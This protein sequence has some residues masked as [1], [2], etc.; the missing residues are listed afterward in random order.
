MF[1]L[2]GHRALVTG[3]GAGMGVGIAH[4]LARQGAAVAVNDLI[5]AKADG[6][7]DEIIAGGGKR[8]PRP[9]T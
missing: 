4:A 2:T 5:E 8:S 7:R 9:S 6:T 3:A 1:E